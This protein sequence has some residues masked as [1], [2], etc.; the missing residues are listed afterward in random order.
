M[1][2]PD[3][4]AAA[5]QLARFLAGP[6][7]AHVT[8]AK[9]VLR[10]L[11]GT[12]DKGLT[13]SKTPTTPIFDTQPGGTHE[14]FSPQGSDQLQGFVDANW[15]PEGETKRKSTTGFV[16]MLHGAAI[17]WHSKL[18][19]ITAQSST[20]SEYIAL[21][22][23]GRHSAYYRKLLGEISRQPSEKQTPMPTWE[24]NQAAIAISNNHTNT[25]K[26]RHLDVKY[27]YVRECVAAGRMDLRYI[28]TSCQIADC[29]TK[30][31]GRVLHHTKGSPKS[32]SA[33]IGSITYGRQACT[34]GP[35]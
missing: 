4:A 22:E 19:T 32:C 29:L 16:L 11:Q 3:I 15:A 34:H 2:R 17:A 9:H 6:T 23:I 33:S 18:Q 13:Y 14:A 27:H 8:A 30:N 35:F 31:L 5:N 20:E 25:S 24:D 7:R 26:L 10:Y 12:S 1:T 21:S 28:P